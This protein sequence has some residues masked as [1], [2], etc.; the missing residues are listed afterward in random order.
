MDHFPGITPYERYSNDLLNEMRAIRILLERNAQAVE[1][2]VSK[3]KEKAVQA[4][5]KKGADDK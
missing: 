5:R 2:P 3:T 4:E 1:Q